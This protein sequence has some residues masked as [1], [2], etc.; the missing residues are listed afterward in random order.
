M[1]SFLQN[2]DL[3]KAIIL[4]SA[5]LLPA[6]GYWAYH[7][8]G[9]IQIG[10]DAI[11]SA[12]APGGELEEIGKFQKAIEEQKRNTTSAGVAESESSYFTNQIIKGAERLKRVNFEIG[13][14]QELKVQNKAIDRVVPIEFKQEGAQKQLPLFRDELN[15]ILYNVESQSPAWKLRTLEIRNADISAAARNKAP[16]PELEDQ[17]IVQRLQFAS[18]RPL[19]R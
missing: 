8:H 6:V 2:L 12:L 16:P 17:W 3:Y 9:Q 10:R 4:L 5:L 7:L 1:K 19:R 11:A 13:S 15:I 14:V 18:R